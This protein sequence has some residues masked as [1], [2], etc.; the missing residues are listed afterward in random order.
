MGH[1]SSVD[2][3]LKL[4]LDILFPHIAKEYHAHHGVSESYINKLI[5]LVAKFG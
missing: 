4:D 5:W 1:E 3:M 2:I